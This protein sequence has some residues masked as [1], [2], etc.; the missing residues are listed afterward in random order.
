MVDQISVRREEIKVKMYKNSEKKTFFVLR[1]MSILLL[2]KKYAVTKFS[3]G[4]KEK[5]K[6]NFKKSFRK[7]SF[8]ITALN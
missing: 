3:S 6:E 7:R 2:H 1:H 8:L 5:K 4:S